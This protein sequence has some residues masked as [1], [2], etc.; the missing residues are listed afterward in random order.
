[1]ESLKKWLK[2]DKKFLIIF[3]ILCCLSLLY[4][5]PI[6]RSQQLYMDDLGRSY[7][8]YYGWEGDIRP[9]SDILMKL[10]SNGNVIIYNIAPLTQILGIVLL[11]YSLVLFLKRYLNNM[12]V[13]TS[14]LMLLFCIVCPF[15]LE[16]LSYKFDSLMM[17]LALSLMIAIFS[18]PEDYKWWIKLIIS[19]VFLVASLCLYQANLGAF[20]SL[21]A[22]EVV[23]G[24]A[25]NDKIV[26]ILKKVG[27]RILIFGLSSVIYRLCIYNIVQ[28]NLYTSQRTQVILFS[29]S[30]IN[31][32]VNNFKHYYTMFLS[33][34]PS[35]KWILVLCGILSIIAIIAFIKNQCLIKEK[36]TKR[37]FLEIFYIILLPIIVSLFAILPVI[38][39]NTPLESMFVTRSLISTTVITLITGITIGYLTTLGHKWKIINI[40]MIVC[41][42]STFT[43]SYNYTNTY[44]I[45]YNYENE[46]SIEIAHEIS[47]IQ[48]KQNV[49][50]ISVCGA[51]K[52]SHQASQMISTTPY[53]Q[54]LI[55]P[56][57][58][59]NSDWGP[60]TTLSYLQNPLTHTQFTKKD[61]KYIQK[62]QPVVNTTDHKIYIN[63]KKIIVSFY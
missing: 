56:L 15:A 23:F 17:L 13:L 22:F 31:T 52:M 12:G 41:L 61:L 63:G 28:T 59:D 48:V 10:L 37:K 44:N 30:G 58:N 4:A 38:V 51:I 49:S 53:Y 16:S 8:G 47:K 40:A 21:S 55:K 34:I 45:E 9:L 43:F 3:V 5:L 19:C 6:L 26:E 50:E 57:W 42:I 33:L 11:S 46:I 54:Y 29:K 39:L 20:L 18:I 35:F 24:I 2:L 60:V 32:V 62:N 25:R 14:V 7:Y 1:M 27:N 36:N